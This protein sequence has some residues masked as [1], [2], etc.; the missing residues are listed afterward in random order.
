[1][2]EGLNPSELFEGCGWP[3]GYRF[4]LQAAVS[5]IVRLVSTSLVTA[6]GMTF[7]LLDISLAGRPSLMPSSIPRIILI[8]MLPLVLRHDFFF[9]LRREGPMGI[10]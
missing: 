5:L 8:A 9:P 7:N 10:F 6:V 3:M 2:V 4:E 1:M